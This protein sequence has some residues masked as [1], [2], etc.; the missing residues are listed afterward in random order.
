MFD[1]LVVDDEEDICE[2]LAEELGTAGFKAVSAMT[3][4]EA[5][6]LSETNEWKL[7]LVDL[8]L[9]TSMTGL[10]VIRALRARWPKAVVIAMTGY[11]DVGLRQE[12]EKLGVAAYFGKPDDIRPE[13]FKKK[14]QAI[15][16]QK[17]RAGNH[18]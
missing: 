11:V 16:W 10:D 13:V 8:K 2:I 12:T 14:I 15:L 3:G 7:C 4:E 17:E 18:E 1:A 9:A 6:R 5:L